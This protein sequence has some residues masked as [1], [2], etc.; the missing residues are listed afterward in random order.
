MDQQEIAGVVDHQGQPAAALFLG[1]AEPLVTRAQAAGG[2]AEDQHAEPVTVGIGDGIVETLAD[3][4]EAAQIVMLIEQRGAAGQFVGRQQADLDARE[5]EW[6][7]RG[8]EAGARAH[9]P[10]RKKLGRICSVNWVNPL[11]ST[12]LV[13]VE[14]LLWWARPGCFISCLM[15]EK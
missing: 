1:P 9:I 4:F 8:G 7:L 2:S 15:T 14:D 12:H 10:E 13:E 5:K 3:G 11:H 6:L